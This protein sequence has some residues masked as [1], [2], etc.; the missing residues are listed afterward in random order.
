MARLESP[1]RWPRPPFS[2]FICKA[3][4]GT[5]WAVAH[6]RPRLRRKLA[7]S[8]PQR[9]S[10]GQSDA[11]E[12]PTSPQKMTVRRGTLEMTSSS[13]C[14]PRNQRGAAKLF[15]ASSIL[16]AAA[17]PR[18]GIGQLHLIML[19]YNPSAH[20]ELQEA[21]LTPL[22]LPAR[23]EAHHQRGESGR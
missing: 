1:P 22:R 8:L 9:P 6:E 4:Y 18:Q 12:R 5:L 23:E 3:S 15:A 13:H 16:A 17:L 21:A 20:A 2:S 10:E 19:C 11:I 7:S 14:T